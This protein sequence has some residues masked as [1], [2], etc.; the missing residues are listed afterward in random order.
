MIAFGSE[1]RPKTGAQAPSD[2]I[3]THLTQQ[4]AKLNA[5]IELLAPGENRQRVRFDEHG[6]LVPHL[7][8]RPQI[9]FQSCSGRN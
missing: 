5:R 2:R 3:N 9:E 6:E 7:T 4:N 1:P 8:A